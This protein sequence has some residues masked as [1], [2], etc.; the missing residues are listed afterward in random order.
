MTRALGIA[1]VVIGS[2]AAFGWCYLAFANNPPMVM[3]R[4]AALLVAWD[5]ANRAA[6]GL[7]RLRRSRGVA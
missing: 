7:L 4:A 3:L 6:R 1:I 5:A 2:I